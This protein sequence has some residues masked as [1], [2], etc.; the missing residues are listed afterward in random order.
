M[1]DVWANTADCQ[2]T[3]RHPDIPAWDTVTAEMKPILTR[4]M[5]VYAGYMEFTDHNVGRVVDTQEKLNILDDTLIYYI[6]GDNGASAEG[7]INGSFNEMSYFNG[8]Q[9]LETA[10]YLTARIDKLGRPVLIQGKTQLLVGGMGR[11]SENCVSTLR[12]NPTPSPRKSSCQRTAQE[13]SSS[14]RVP[15]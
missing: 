11:L 1:L 14:V 3:G 6:V 7:G 5:E 2:L 9:G 8:L 15:T 12:T 13:E 4:Q 10:E